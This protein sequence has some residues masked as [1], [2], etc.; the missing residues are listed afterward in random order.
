MK[1]KKN[2]GF[3]LTEVM[4][5]TAIVGIITMVG[6]P[7]YQAYK[8]KAIVAE[9]RT[10]LNSMWTAQ[11]AFFMANDRF[12]TVAD[13]A[14]DGSWW[15][16]FLSDNELGLIVPSNAKYDYGNWMLEDPRLLGFANL[17]NFWTTKLASCS[18]DWG[19]QRLVW[20]D[21]KLD[22][23]TGWADGSGVHNGLAGCF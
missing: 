10:T 11:H 1:L 19:D 16:A 6:V 14:A 17:K 3:T 18:N 12:S 5:V 20:V 9:A 4:A 2:E 7:K 21:K 13:P 23:G 22:S 15:T 8:A